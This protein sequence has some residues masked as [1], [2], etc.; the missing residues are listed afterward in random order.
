MSE[1]KHPS[2]RRILVIDDNQA[3][4][5]DFRKIFEPELG[6]NTA[7]DAV[8]SAMLGDTVSAASTVDF[9]I[10][11][12]FQG[13][14]GLAL[15][16]RALAENS[17][18]AMAFVDVRM[19][20]GWDGVETVAHIW[21]QYPELQVV[22]CT[23]YSD[24]SFDDMINKLG[25]TDRLVILKKPFDSIEVLQLAHAMT[26]KWRLYRQ[27]R[28]RLEDLEHMVQERTAELKHTNLELTAAND[29]LAEE[30]KRA[31]EL[32]KAALVA[33]Q[34]KSQFLAVMSHEIRTPMNGII[35]MTELLL[36]TPLSEEQHEFAE[37]V[38]T[39]ANSLLAIL[40]DILDFS[41]I[42]AGKLAI[43]QLDFNLHETLAQVVAL[44]AEPAERKCL[45]LSCSIA[46]NVPALLR[47]DPNRLRQVVLNL[48][49]N[50]VK[51]TSQ[52]Q[53]SLE[54]TLVS[55][56]VDSAELRF[57]IRDT[58]PGFPES[59]R[60]KLFQPFT[61]ADSSTTRTFGGTGL[62]LAICR[63]LVALMGG[64]IGVESEVGKGSTFWFKLRLEK[65]FPV[66]TPS[67]PSRVASSGPGDVPQMAKS[68]CHRDDLAALPVPC[69]QPSVLLVEDN[70][71]NQILAK[72]LLEK[73]GCNV[74]I[75]MNGIEALSAL[76]QNRYHVIFMDCHMP[77]MDGYETTRSIRANETRQSLPRACIVAM[78]ANAMKGDREVCLE[79][80]MDDYIAKPLNADELKAVL[81]RNLAPP[82][83][84]SPLESYPTRA[85]AQ[86]SGPCH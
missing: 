72:R 42:E 51:F 14:E 36:D 19:P 78:T 32:A 9:Q 54:V 34:A 65:Q 55:D 85:L 28:A 69:D 4:H 47:G 44:M 82:D 31:S 30:C 2:H 11:F 73:Q 66:T 6:Q 67:M 41:K 56:A 35:G 5:Q 17:P 75:A 81:R 40:N 25:H 71:V 13:Q 29:R 15:I 83:R 61:Q 46:P 22:I 70:R 39:S 21:E 16:Q 38:K 76:E 43:E 64:E 50:A 52:G 20:P 10:D 59:T 48:L 57:S 60:Q 86:S 45:A 7:L 80:G 23:A 49:S 79:A 3:I 24:Y 12:A 33:S 53:A 68:S 1:S 27:A 62:G 74:N 77:E 26:E 63:R 18:Y 58:G 37:T 84:R 8:E